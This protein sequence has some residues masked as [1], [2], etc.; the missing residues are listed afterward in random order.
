MTKHFSF[1]TLLFVAGAA[2]VFSL[3]TLAHPT[4]ALAGLPPIN[5]NRITSLYD[6]FSANDN[7]EQDWGYSALVEYNGKRILFDAGNNAD[8]FKR[9]VDKL[10]LDLRTIDFAVLSHP[11]ADHL[12]G[13]NYLAQV[14]PD[15]KIYLPFDLHGLGASPSVFRFGGPDPNAASALPPEQRY[16][17]TGATEVNLLPS[18][19]FYRARNVEYLR[20]NLDVAPGI[21]IIATKSPYL[22]GFNG[23]PPNSPEKP[24]LS[25]LPELSLSLDTSRG[26]VLVVGC[27]HTG[28]EEI[29]KATRNATGKPVDTVAG[30][31]HLF[32]YDQAYVLALVDKVKNELGVRR[33]SPS[34]CTGHLAFKAFKDAYQDG[35][36]YGGLGSQ[37]IFPA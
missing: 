28:V 12:S 19:R 24:A 21:K 10:G 34:H 5:E 1:L 35:Y 18:G 30:G 11:H 14:N 27:S 13:F 26:E 16:Y 22:G 25:G 6:A 29:I 9:N 36:I 31:F 33:V 32:P 8:L 7:L 15:V 2:I 23:Y 17:G 37:L 20:E 3:T 4:R